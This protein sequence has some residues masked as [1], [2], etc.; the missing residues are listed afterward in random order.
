[1]EWVEVTGK[2]V[3]E[4]KEEALDQ[5]GVTESDAEVVVLTE[6]K[7]GLFGRVRG[8]ARVRARVRPVGPRPKRQRRPHDRSRS[9]GGSSGGRNGGENRETGTDRPRE[10][11][12]APDGD[13]SSDAVEHRAGGAGGSGNGSGGAKRRRRRGGRGR[14][15]ARS[16]TGAGTAGGDRPGANTDGE[17]SAAGSTA[18][19]TERPPGTG[20]GDGAGRASMG[21]GTSGGR[22]ETR[23]H[24]ATKEESTVAEGMT[25]QEQAEIGR[26]FLEGLVERYGLSARVEV[27]ELDEETVE[28]AATGDGLG[29]LVGP[30]GA[31]LAA[32][33]DVTR[34]VVQRR[35]P[36]RTDRILVDVAGYRERRATALRRFTEQVS[37]EVMSSGEERALEPM[38]PADRK[39]VH[40]TAAGIDGVE[41]RSDGEDPHRFVVIAPVG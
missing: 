16:S 39:V 14:G 32:L 9:G 1:M 37:A 31:T 36:T 24:A 8:E 12:A 35:F 40:D 7:T 6:P 23:R 26:E 19:A 2:T 17:M 29:M 21:D 25:L 15:G 30:K 18:P 22:Q 10:R 20:G 13:G 4:A 41:S 38:S 3:D 28:L 34:A 5:L 33:Q 27:R 11:A